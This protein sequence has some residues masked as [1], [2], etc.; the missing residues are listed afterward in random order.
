MALWDQEEEDAPLDT[1]EGDVESATLDLDTF[2]DSPLFYDALREETAQDFRNM[3]NLPTR[4][5]APLEVETETVQMYLY[6]QA[7]ARESY[8]T[9]AALHDLSDLQSAAHGIRL[10]LERQHRRTKKERKRKQKEAKRD[11]LIPVRHITPREY[12]TAKA[13]NL[14]NRTAPASREEPVD[15]IEHISLPPQE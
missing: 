3:F 2:E 11:A 1:T 6:H 15:F 8:D 7:L 9:R 13:S 10:E 14:L 4:Q 5:D 12:N